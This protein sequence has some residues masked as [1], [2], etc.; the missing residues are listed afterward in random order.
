[1]SYLWFPILVLI[2]LLWRGRKETAAGWHDRHV[3]P[4]GLYW[5]IALLYA[6]SGA[7]FSFA[8]FGATHLKFPVSY[9]TLQFVAMAGFIAMVMLF[10]IARRLAKPW[11]EAES[12]PHARRN[13]LHGVW[14]AFGVLG[15]GLGFLPLLLPPPA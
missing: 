10:W 15:I 1:M 5:G 6:L 9:A 11:L 13:H 14:A 12:V 7:T 2:V 4:A 3:L 8:A